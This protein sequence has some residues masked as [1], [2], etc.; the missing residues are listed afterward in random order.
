MVIGRCQKERNMVVS[1]KEIA[2][3][4]G[5]YFSFGF[6]VKFERESERDRFSFFNWKSIFS[7]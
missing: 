3:S 4:G 7:K 1:S 6:V 5:V 2:T